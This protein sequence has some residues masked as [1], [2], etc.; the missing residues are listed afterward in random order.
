MAAARNHETQCKKCG[1]HVFVFEHLMGVPGGKEKEEATCPNCGN[2]VYEAM[3]DG[4]FETSIIEE[5][6]SPILDTCTFGKTIVTDTGI[7][8]SFLATKRENHFRELWRVSGKSEKDYVF[9]ILCHIGEKDIETND[10]TDFCRA[11]L[12]ALKLSQ[13]E[14]FAKE[15]PIHNDFQ[16]YF[17]KT[18]R[19]SG[20]KVNLQIIINEELL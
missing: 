8:Y 3:T 2:V 20:I 17:I 5:Q 7:E 6:E 4:W 9:D 16:K 15:S 13:N 19:G 14:D 11:Y 1:K 10:Y 18:V 12:C